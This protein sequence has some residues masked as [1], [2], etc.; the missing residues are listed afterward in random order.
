MDDMNRSMAVY[1]LEKA[2]TDLRSARSSLENGFYE[3]SAN[4]SYYAIFHAARAVL[5]ADGQ[6]FSKHSGVIAFFNRDYIKSGILE[7]KLGRILRDAFEI[8]TDCDYE[9]FFVISK[10]EVE[11]QVENAEYFVGR[12]EA[13]LGE[14]LGE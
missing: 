11:R 3:T 10:G 1:R 6:S 2:K 7:R 4:R 5:V 14:R 9:D 8:R 12:I 13:Y